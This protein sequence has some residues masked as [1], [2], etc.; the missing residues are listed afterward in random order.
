MIGWPSRMVSSPGLARGSPPLRCG[1][2][3][4]AAAVRRTELG[5]SHMKRFLVYLAFVVTLVLASL[6]DFGFP[7]NH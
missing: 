2:V 5:G 4:Q 1:D 3:K 6:A 7:W